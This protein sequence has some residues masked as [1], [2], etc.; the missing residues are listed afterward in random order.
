MRRIAF[1]LTLGFIFTIPWEAAIHIGAFGRLSKAV[2]VVTALMWVLSV[3]TRGRIR[4]PDAFVKA[5]FLVI[6]WSGMTL[7]WSIDPTSTMKGFITYLQL[8]GMVYLLWDLIET[9]RQ[10]EACLQTYVIGAYVSCV[11]IFVNWMTAPPTK[12]PEHQRIKALGFEVDGIALIIA[13]A[14]PVAWYLATGSN[15]GRRRPGLTT[16]NLVYVPVA[17]FAMVLTGTRGASLASIP[18]ALFVLWT[19]RHTPGKRRLLAWVAVA[20]TVA[21]VAW[22]APQEPLERITGSVSDVTTG[23]SLSGRTDIWQ[24]GTQTFYDNA[25]TGV[26]LD[27]FRASNTFGKE[28]HNTALSVL[29]ETGMVGFLF[30]GAAVLISLLYVW[31]RAGWMAWYWRTQLAA[32]LLGSLSLSLEDSKSVWLFL[33]LAVVSATAAQRERPSAATAGAQLGSSS[34]RPAPVSS[35]RDR[36][37]HG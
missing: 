37:G 29:V 36:I 4:P 31:R 3:I 17:L 2:G 34:R 15:L 30:L 9:E 11:S 1:W 26:G 5:Y 14:V 25:V 13:L 32:L 27:A 35:A 21:A 18:T 6:V 33:T 8:F 23:D 28:A 12:Y 16:V 19:L 10:V 7:F 24:Q 22:Y 20:A